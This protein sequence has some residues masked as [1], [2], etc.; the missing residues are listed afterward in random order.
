[1]TRQR[2]GLARI[3][4]GVMWASASVSTVAATCSTVTAMA[5]GHAIAAEVWAAM[6]VV[7]IM[8]SV[9][10]SSAVRQLRGTNR[11]RR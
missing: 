9:A 2:V 7:N 3:P 11:R 6:G 4:L 8:G 5:H 1:M 10:V